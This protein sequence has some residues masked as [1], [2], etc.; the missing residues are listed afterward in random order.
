MDLETLLFNLEKVFKLLPKFAYQVEEVCGDYYYKQTSMDEAVSKA[1]YFNEDPNTLLHT[2]D[3][4][5]HFVQDNINKKLP[6]DGPLWR[7]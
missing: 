3:D 4:L 5:L 2:S 6:L 7:I 1:V